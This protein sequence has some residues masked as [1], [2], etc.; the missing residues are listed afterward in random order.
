[1]TGLGS[2]VRLA[3]RRSRWFYALWLLG[4][5]SVVPATAAA[6]ETIIG[7]GGSAALDLLAANP[8][9]R[10]M[11]GPPVDLSTPGG[12]T[13]WRVGTFAATVAGVMTLLGV[14]R[15]T[16]ADEE[17]GRTELLRSG[18][19]GRHVPLTAAVLTALVACAVLALGIAVSMVAVGE[20]V[21]GSI[22]FGA[23][24]GLVAAVFAGVGAVTAQLGSTARA[25]RGLGMAV[26]GGAYVLRAVT[27]A[28]PD[29]SAA[30]PWHW[31][32]PVE[33]MALA[34]PYADE[35]WWVLLLPL[36]LTVA[37]V[38]VAF[39]L[40]ASRDHGAGMRPVRP[41]RDRAPAGLLSAEGLAWRLQRGSVLGWAIGLTIF[42]L[43][44]G[45]LS[46][47]FRTMLDDL[48]QFEI[49][50][51]RLGRGAEDLVDAFF[52]AMLGIV[53]IL[54][55]ILGVLLWQRLAA[56]E[57]RGHAELL[58]A[59]SLPRPR[60]A[61]SHLLVAALLPVALL[62][63]VGALL[64]T[65]EALSQD[66]PGLV[67]QVLGAALAL[68]PGGLLILGLAVLLHGWAPHL[69]WLV[70]VVIG[71]SL[72]IVWVG[73]V[74]GLPGWVTRLTPWDP[75]P[76]IPVEEM[77]WTPVLLMTLA[78]VAL[79]GLGLWGYRRRDLRLT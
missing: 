49:V 65:P 37:L 29:T 39:A 5:I 79:M 23:G 34:R 52:V 8:T 45:S 41:G 55:A 20:P 3:L 22:A 42:A 7:P 28:Q 57:R 73:S 44:M 11:L 32:S 33:W 46:G 24:T 12:F 71:W 63:L 61:L 10:A 16:R 40:E 53:A 70:W 78:A 76:A 48:P 60:L 35:R 51:R 58:L 1:M 69:D 27:D 68:A 77:D 59:T 64:A 9:M 6:Y 4:L 47:S 67:G 18:V 75:L 50:L 19:V 25:A 43:A 54:I 14:I 56:E 2:L 66:S 72:F 17:E 74:L 26:L 38:A 36:A 13:V 31:L 21:P 30:Y 15:S 62:A